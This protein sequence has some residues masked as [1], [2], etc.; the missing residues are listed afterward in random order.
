MLL[1]TRFRVVII[2]S[3]QQ[4]RVLINSRSLKQEKLHQTTPAAGSAAH[5]ALFW[6]HMWTGAEP[7]HTAATLFWTLF[8]VNKVVHE[9]NESRQH[10]PHISHIWYTKS[11]SRNLNETCFWHD[12]TWSWTSYIGLSV[13]EWKTSR[14][15]RTGAGQ[16]DPKLRG[17]IL[18]PLNQ[19][20]GF[21]N[22]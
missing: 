6:S 13:H 11:V 3:G 20:H 16:K 10:R 18:Q 5:H 22:Q 17:E 19:W 8:W 7:P 12:A 14:T 21:F 4:D 1:L 9:P 15:T 2:G